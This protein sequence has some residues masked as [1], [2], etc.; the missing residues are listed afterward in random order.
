MYICLVNQQSK[1]AIRYWEEGDRP[2]E[3]LLQ[4]GKQQLNNAEL[5]AILI[6]SGNKQL[7]AVE[8]S[9][10][11]LN[12][13]Q[14]DISL[15]G[16]QSVID[17]QRFKGIG[18]AKAISIVAALELG[19]RRQAENLPQKQKISSSKDVYQLFVAALAD[20]YHEEF[21]VVFLNHRNGII[22]KEKISTGGLSATVV[23]VRIVLKKALQ[24]LASGIILVHNHPS[25]SLMASQADKQ[26][27]NKLKEAAKLLDI[28]LLDHVIVAD[29]G[30]YS[31][32][33]E[34]M[35]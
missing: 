20:L 19:R 6:G 24:K 18:Q 14:D 1:L 35:I 4:K 22:G 16:K 3:K 9:Q 7:S 11:I 27:T 15:L 5:L 25:G 32:A 29:T 26:L 10:Q 17:L 33:D 34:G 12:D 8:L 28:S 30:Y 23:D 2:R 13:V 31:F 21:W